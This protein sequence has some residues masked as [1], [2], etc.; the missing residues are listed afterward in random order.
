SSKSKKMSVS[1][2]LPRRWIY[3][4]RAWKS[5]LTSLPTA[6]RLTSK[7]S[8]VERLKTSIFRVDDKTKSPDQSSD[9]SNTWIQA[10]AEAENLVNHK[11]G[12]HIDPVQLVGKDMADLTKNIKQLLG[13]KHP[14]L[15]AVNKYYFNAQGKH[16]RPL[17]VLLMSQATSIAPKRHNKALT[18]TY[19]IIDISLTP[20]LVLNEGM[21]SLDRDTPARYLPTFS[22]NQTFILPTQRRLAEIAE[23]IH[24]ASLFHD[25]VIDIS[26]SRRNQPSANSCFGNKIAI[27]AGDFLLA[28]AS[29]ALARLRNP[30]VI[31]LLAT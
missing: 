14:M 18:D 2:T 29:V 9:N 5:Q 12:S 15:N 6:D 1:T 25:D 19:Q 10:I 21:T 31:E 13:S 27:L 4:L 20:Q 23:M 16:I 30:E 8:F 7:P 24:T 3:L 28:R 11:G 22:A 26:N 17:I